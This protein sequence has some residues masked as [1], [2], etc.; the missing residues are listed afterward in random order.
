VLHEGIVRVQ[1][2]IERLPHEQEEISMTDAVRVAVNRD[3]ASELCSAFRK[4]DWTP[5][6]GQTKALP[7]TAPTNHASNVRY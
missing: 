7:H 2:A 1:D 4:F 6:F 5:E 3:P